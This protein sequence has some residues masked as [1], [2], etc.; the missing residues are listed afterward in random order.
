[1][2]T[3]WRFVL[4]VFGLMG[5]RLAGAGFGLLSQLLLA[6]YFLAHDVGIA[7]LAMSITG[8]V[9]MVIT[10]GYTAIGMTYLARYF[11]LD[12][13]GLVD[14]FIVAARR[15]MLIASAIVLVIAITAP[16]LPLAPEL[17]L[18]I[19]F[20]GLAALPHALIRLDNAIANSQR[21]F[22]LA[23]VPDFVFRSG[24]LV[25]FILGMVFFTGNRDVLP[26]LVAFTII[27]FAVA[28]GQA[29]LLGR[30]SAVVPTRTK[31][32]R[33]LR[34]RY[35]NRA[36]AMLFVY[37]VTYT[38]ADLI[39]MLA[40]FLLPTPDVAILGVAIRLAALVG[41]FSSASQ[42][43]V[44]RDLATAIKDSQPARVNEL[45]LR[46]NLVGIAT[47][48]L[49]ILGVAVL[50]PFML[51]F[52]G[53]HYA[54]AYWPLLIFLGSQMFR[55]LGGM[56]GQLLALGGHQLRSATLC[57]VVVVILVGLAVLLAP[58]FGVSGIALAALVA[59]AV[60]AVALAFQAQKLEG[61]RGDIVGLLTLR[62][63]R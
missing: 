24:L 30:D 14:G 38:T 60:W 16:F 15:D 4:P 23:Y 18:A 19:L 26:V 53:S 46:T 44:L 7:F 36:A 12:R 48:A 61:R 47:M 41:F 51:T 56:N 6:R 2:K 11:A 27:T 29:A 40:G 49:A 34:P 9:S 25:I 37:V 42:Q 1:M 32:R 3:L 33:D 13:Q 45:L 35:R 5:A 17:G 58:Q 10:C 8:F 43:F 21:R 52:F 31:P 22:H 54:A 63:A 59:E 50:G 28:L 62:A 57:L 55:T 39:V 20:G